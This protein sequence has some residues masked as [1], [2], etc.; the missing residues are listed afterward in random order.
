MLSG[1]SN[2]HYM[3]R[4]GVKIIVFSVFTS[5]EVSSSLNGTHVY[6]E[7]ILTF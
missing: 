5:P 3:L 1:I 6:L 2:G 4:N 7:T